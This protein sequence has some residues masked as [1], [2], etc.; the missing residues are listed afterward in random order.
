MFYIFTLTFSIF[1]FEYYKTAIMKRLFLAFFACILMNVTCFS[2]SP[3][4]GLIGYWPF[5][6]NAVENYFYYPATVD[7]ATLTTDRF[8]SPNSAFYFDGI[9]DFILSNESLFLTNKVTVS[10]WVKFTD[11]LGTMLFLARYSSWDDHGFIIGKNAPGQ[12]YFA[13]RD[14]N[15][16]YNSSPLSKESFADDQWH[17]LV[18]VCDV[19]I[20][21][22]W[23]DGVFEGSDTTDHTVVNLETNG[24]SMC[25]G[26]EYGSNSL[27][28]QGFLDD[29]RVYNRAL[30]DSEIQAIYQDNTSGIADQR[31]DICT[32]YPNPASDK[33]RFVNINPDH[34]KI[35]NSQGQLVLNDIIETDSR[36]VDVSSLPIGLYY[37]EASEGALLYNQ[38]FIK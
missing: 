12:L 27:H 7:G 5:E 6:G 8:G 37:L 30:S 35:Y 31:N 9:N 34:V 23:V 2:Q 20:W 13:G 1:L 33:L 3:T 14:G 16:E 17:F 21:S 19:T 15:N 22:L 4:T 26:K 32:I 11:T 18:G 36:V 10:C 28:Y 25:F 38:K 24:Y 29:I